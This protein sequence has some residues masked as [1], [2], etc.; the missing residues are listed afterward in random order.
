M[1]LAGSRVGGERQREAVIAHHAEAAATEEAA[2]AT[3]E[4][5]DR[6]DDGGGV[7][8]LAQRKALAAQEPQP[9]AAR[10]E[11]T[12]VVREPAVP[13]LRP[14]QTVAGGRVARMAGGVPGAA[15]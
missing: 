4:E 15:Q 7:T 10:S 3:E 13:E 9:R 2:Q 14:G 8:G 12:A 5:S 11:Q 1:L 6:D